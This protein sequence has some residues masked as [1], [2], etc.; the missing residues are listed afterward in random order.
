M[1]GPDVKQSADGRQLPVEIQLAGAE[2]LGATHGSAKKEQSLPRLDA[3]RQVI[4][5]LDVR[6]ELRHE[7]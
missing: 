3:A 2:R 1:H 5:A 7:R 4:A 6:A